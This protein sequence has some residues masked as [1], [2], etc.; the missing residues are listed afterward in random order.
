MFGNNMGT[1][2]L[3]TSPAS[4]A[5]SEPLYWVASYHNETNVVHLKVGSLSCQCIETMIE[6]IYLK[7]ANTGTTD[8]NANILLDF[9]ITGFG[10]STSISSPLLSP[11]SGIFNISNTLDEPELIIPVAT[12][13]AIPAPRE[14]NYTFPATS[15]T[16]LSLLSPD[17]AG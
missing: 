15:V 16:V 2:V 14:L 6:F 3:A 9:S 13:F 1:H 12:S 10:T 4:T 11:I 17:L 8:L 7:V 5:D